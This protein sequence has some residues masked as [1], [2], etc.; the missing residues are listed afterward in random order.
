MILHTCEPTKG[1]FSIHIREGKKWYWGESTP[2]WAP[3]G[4]HNVLLFKD[5]YV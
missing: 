5:V 1:F 2:Q 4:C 3:L